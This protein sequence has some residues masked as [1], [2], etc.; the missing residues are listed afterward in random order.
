MHARLFGLRSQHLR[1]SSFLRRNTHISPNHW[2]EWVDG[3]G[4]DKEIVKNN[5]RTINKGDGTE[6]ECQLYEIFGP[7]K[8]HEIN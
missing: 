2:K 4:V 6:T 5:L 1:E 3:S 8:R 7:K